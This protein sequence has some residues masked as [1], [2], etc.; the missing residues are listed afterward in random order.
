MNRLERIR[1]CLL[2]GA[3]GDALGAPVEFLGWTAI[4]KQFGAAGIADLQSAYGVMGAITDDTQM[5]LFTAEGLLRSWVRGYSRGLC[6][7]PSVI[8]HALLRWL[9]TQ[10]HEP[11][12]AVTLN[13]WLVQERA[14]W[15]RRAP[16]NTCVSALMA[17]RHLGFAAENN[18]KGCGAVM[19]V[20][21]C[22]FFAEPFETAS[23]SGRLTHGHPA[24]Y[25]AAG[26]FADILQRMSEQT[27]SLEHALSESL[28]AHGQKPGMD[29]VRTSLEKV[30]FYFYEG[31]QPTPD[32]ID[33]FGGGWIAEE[34]LAIGVWCAL[35]APSFEQGVINAVNH[36]GDSDSTGLI[37][38]HLLG[39]QYG[40]TAIPA[41]WLERLEL[42]N[43]IEKVA[44]D[45]E[46]V[47]RDYQGG[48]GALDS[49]IEVHY[50][51]N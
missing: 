2:G 14:L 27:V 6:N 18:S 46:R 12:T 1:G 49:D 20:A 34:A 44:A 38:G 50:P 26:L 31:Y 3:V 17:S 35:S 16:G 11:L 13:G 28:A 45:I 40:P 4:E 36:S 22:A 41:R 21:P 7:V 5:M 23:E 47:P 9:M 10:D 29:E 32:R 15:S 43:V 51:G 25:H 8:H 24:G 39:I 48:A 33:E 19:R 30:L 42:R 37:A